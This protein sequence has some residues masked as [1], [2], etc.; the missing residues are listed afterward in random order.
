MRATSG[1]DLERRPVSVPMRTARPREPTNPVASPR[2]STKE[3]R[4]KRHV[5]PPRYTCVLGARELMGVLAVVGPLGTLI[6][7]WVLPQASLM[8]GLPLTAARR[9]PAS[10]VRV[11]RVIHLTM[12]QN[13]RKARYILAPDVDWDVFVGGVQERLQLG[14]I[15]RIETSAGERIMSVADLMHEDHL[16]IHSDNP[17]PG[18]RGRQLI[19][20]GQQ[21]QQQQQGGG[22][23]G[24]WDDGTTP[25]ADLQTPLG[26][27]PP[28]QRRYAWP[29]DKTLLQPTFFNGLMRRNS[30][31]GGGTGLKPSVGVGLAPSMLATAAAGALTGEP[32]GEA[33]DVHPPDPNAPQAR[34][35]PSPAH[36]PATPSRLTPSLPLI[37]W[38]V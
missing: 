15:S 30:S 9:S 2:G 7:L 6:S 3:K 22:G 13:E 27:Q 36:L 18:T 29:S 31:S 24:G 16:V 32:H 21:Q 38:R 5:P 37:C 12:A 8:D 20:Q 14:A 10:G 25:V 19:Q 1:S 33:A 17:L 28:P 23:G 34:P 4:G 26:Q 11:P 35:T